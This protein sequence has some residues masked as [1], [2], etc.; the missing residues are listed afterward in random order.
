MSHEPPI[1]DAARSPYPLQPPPAAS[2][3]AAAADRPPAGQQAKYADE[4]HPNGR[5]DS[6][7]DRARETFDRVKESPYGLGA[8]I[9]IGSAALL[10]A[11]LYARRGSRAES[12]T[13]RAV[14]RPRRTARVEPGATRGANPEVPK[15]TPSAGP[16]QSRAKA[17]P[18]A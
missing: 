5:G 13:A 1:P 6:L 16:K 8:A 4:P 14:N 18:E 10:A 9:G 7:V 11:V 17:E 3:D 15:R 12:S 2:L